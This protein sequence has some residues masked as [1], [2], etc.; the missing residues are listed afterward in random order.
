MLVIF[1][2]LDHDMFFHLNVIETI[3]NIL[4]SKIKEEESQTYARRITYMIYL[5]AH[6]P[7]LKRVITSLDIRTSISLEPLNWINHLNTIFICNL[8]LDSQNVFCVALKRSWNPKKCVIC[9]CTLKVVV[10]VALTLEFS[11][12]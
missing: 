10:I 6:L 2:R 3:E 4:W 9:N 5:Y 11:Q 12:V 1:I 8:I 7:V